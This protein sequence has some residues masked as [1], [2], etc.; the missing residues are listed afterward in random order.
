MTASKLRE[1]SN[2]NIKD[3]DAAGLKNIESVMIDTEQDISARVQSFLN[4]IENPYCFLVG[5]TPVKISFS[6][7]GKPLDNALLHYFLSLKQ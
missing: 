1:M 3:V 4:Q 6:N 7:Q 2:T 5:N